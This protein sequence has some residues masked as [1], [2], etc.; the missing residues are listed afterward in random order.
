MPYYTY[1]CRGCGNLQSDVRLIDE[2]H[3]AP[4]CHKCKG[5]TGLVVD[6][7]R[8]IVKDPAGGPRNNWR[9]KP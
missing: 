4:K 5:E 3:D 8:G 9:G 2:R 6:P 7:V 1:Q